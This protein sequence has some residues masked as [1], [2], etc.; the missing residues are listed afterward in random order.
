M[1]GVV[2]CGTKIIVVSLKTRTKILSGIALVHV[3]KLIASESLIRII[4]CSISFMNNLVY[5]IIHCIFCTISLSNSV[6]LLPR[7]VKK[8]LTRKNTT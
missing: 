2:T 1:T 4:G 6:Q 3:V 7:E 5:Y 8:K